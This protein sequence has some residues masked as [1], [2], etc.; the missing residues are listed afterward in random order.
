MA[1]NLTLARP[2]AETA[3]ELAIGQ[4][5]DSGRLSSWESALT[6]FA[7][8][9]AQEEARRLIGSP[10][11]NIDQLVGVIVETAAVQDAEQQTFLRVMAENHRLTVMAE[12]LV[13][14]QALRAAH[15]AVLSAVIRSAFPLSDVQKAEV[16]ATL[17]A[18]FGKPVRSEVQIDE[19]LI[20]GVCI[21]IGD[22]IIDASV[23]G[24]LAQMATALTN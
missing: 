17:Q 18:R 7:E 20:G 14:F 2:Y 3:F 24:K 4:A 1:E 9:L 12:V 10:G 22:Q 16:D 13:H 11:L 23:S 6:R 15:E 8:V 21:Q 5:G 19:S